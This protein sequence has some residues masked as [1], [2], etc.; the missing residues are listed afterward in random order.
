M[1]GEGTLAQ[2]HRRSWESVHT[3]TKKVGSLTVSSRHTRYSISS[4]FCS[5][6][7]KQMI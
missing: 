1:G 7:L 6:L 2:R 3:N 5:V 4:L